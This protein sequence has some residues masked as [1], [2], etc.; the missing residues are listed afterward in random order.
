MKFW[1]PGI[2]VRNLDKAIEYYSSVMGIGPFVKKEVKTKNGQFRGKP[3]ELTIRVAQAKMGD[4]E[5]ELIQADPGDNPF[6]EFLNAHGEGIHHLAFQV[7]DIESEIVKL[8]KKGLEV[9]IR[10]ETNSEKEFAYL[11]SAPPGGIIIQLAQRLV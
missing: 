11:E 4:V 5:L 10:A 8:R 3:C 9:L 7:D 1:H 2:V 6:W